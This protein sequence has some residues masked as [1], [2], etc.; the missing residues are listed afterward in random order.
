MRGEEIFSG[1]VGN[2]STTAVYTPI[3][4][5][6]DSDWKAVKSGSAHTLALKTNGT[7]WGWG[8][9][10]A[11]ELSQTA[12]NPSPNNYYT[13]PIQLSPDNDWKDIAAGSNKTFA[14]KNNGTLWA[15]GKNNKYSIGIPNI[16]E[17]A[18]V[19]TL[20]QIGSFSD[21]KKVSTSASGNFTLALKTNNTLW[22]WGDN[23]EGATGT[24]SGALIVPTIQVGIS[25]WKDVAAGENYA[26]G[27][28]SDGTL[29]GWGKSCTVPSAGTSVPVSSLAPIQMST[30][31]DWVKVAAGNCAVF[32]LKSNNTLWAW[33]AYGA[34]WNNGIDTHTSTP[35]LVF[36]CS[37]STSENDKDFSNIVLYPNPTVDKI[38]WA[39][40]IPI[41]KVT[42]YD[43]SWRKIL[44]KNSPENVID[45][46]NLPNGAYMIKLESKDKSIYN[47]KFVKK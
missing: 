12:A 28:K 6:T 47:S 11:C 42:I 19:S 40:N 37:L 22:G 25:T 41:E 20:T 35:V 1:E 9:N 10:N 2:G 26:A 15:R 39:L 38:S 34:L 43:M 3:Q 16:G 46:S 29:W 36:Q 5:G 30:E 44:S 24:G 33:G 18:C 27:I 7:L 13:Q 17:G 8:N 4:I 31:T 32:A 14:I 45:V 23:V 21:W